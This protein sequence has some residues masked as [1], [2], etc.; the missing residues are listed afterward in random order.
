MEWPSTSSLIDSKYVSKSRRL[1]SRILISSLFVVYFSLSH[2][3]GALAQVNRE[4]S[5]ELVKE[6][7]ETP[8]EFLVAQV[9]KLGPVYGA[10]A[11]WSIW[12]PPFLWTNDQLVDFSRIKWPQWDKEQV[13]IAIVPPAGSLKS[14]IILE[15]VNGKVLEE[16]PLNNPFVPDRYDPIRP[17]PSRYRFSITLSNGR[18]ILRTPAYPWLVR[19]NIL[20]CDYEIEQGKDAMADGRV[21]TCLSTLDSIALNADRQWFASMTWPETGNA[22]RRN[23]MSTRDRELRASFRKAGHV[24]ETQRK[25]RRFVVRAG[26]TNAEQIP[27]IEFDYNTIPK[28]ETIKLSATREE[29]TQEMYEVKTS[30]QGGLKIMSFAADQVEQVALRSPQGPNPRLHIQFVGTDDIHPS[31]L[32]TEYLQNRTGIPGLLRKWRGR[33]FLNQN[34]LT[35]SRGEQEQLLGGPGLDLSYASDLWSLEPYAIFDSGLYHP[36]SKISITELQFGVRRSFEFMPEWSAFYLGIHQYQLSGRNPGSSRLGASDS[37]ALGV[38]G[39]ERI[40][41]HYLQ[42]RAAALFSTA[43]GFDAQIE[44]G[45]VWDRKSDFHLT[46]GVF[47]GVSRYSSQ[48]VIPSNRLSE[49]LSEDRVSFGLSIGFL[50]PESRHSRPD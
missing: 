7:P 27:V 1:A 36:N 9:P 41:R 18:A 6:P 12:R 26:V 3:N 8:D 2:L 48:V 33:G 29:K 4:E 28:F 19:K 11:S 14:V 31:I 38:A 10:R 43:S 17:R 50:G 49:T 32:T 37:I 35:S 42:G 13:P 25:G 24:F 15:D 22:I 20:E 34:Q 40:G 44:Y 45:Q 5:L 21:K 47:M 39:L 23:A 46:W 30:A 16:V